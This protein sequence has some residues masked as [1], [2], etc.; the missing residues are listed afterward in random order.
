VPEVGATTSHGAFDA[1]VH[2]TVPAP[3]CERRTVC[4]AVLDVNV[5]PVLMALK[6]SAVLSSAIVGA[7]GVAVSVS[8]LTEPS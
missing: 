6:L 5:V 7:G 4:E 1:A 3:V 8:V 2:V